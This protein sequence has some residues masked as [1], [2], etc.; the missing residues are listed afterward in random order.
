M[1]LILARHGNTFNT[2]DKIVWVGRTEDFPLTQTGEEQARKVAEFVRTKR[3][4]K[5]YCAPLKRTRRFAEI[6]AKD[7]NLSAPILDE[8]L[9]EVDYGAW[10]G[11]SDDEIIALGLESELEAWKNNAV[12]PKS[13]GT[14]KEEI[15]KAINS[16]YQDVV[17]A[18]SDNAIL[19]ISSNGCL[20][21]FL[22]ELDEIPEEIKKTNGKVKTG[23]VCSFGVSSGKCSLNYWNKTPEI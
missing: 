8:R 11:K 10:A 12:W 4:S 3:I 13:W 22:Q 23:G 16:F 1:E 15:A 14:T 20:R 2:G 6:I 7:L 21:F 18:N 17:N 5:I 19:A 9:L